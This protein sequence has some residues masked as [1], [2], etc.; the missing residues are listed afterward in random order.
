MSHLPVD[1]PICLECQALD[2]TFFDPSCSGCRASLLAQEATVAHVFAALRQ[3]VPQVQ[4]R[5]DFL[6]EEALRRGAHP[7]RRGI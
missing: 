6:V 2:L 1:A 5:V 7:V 4:A 3:W